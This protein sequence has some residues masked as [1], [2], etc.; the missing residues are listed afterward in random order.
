MFALIAAILIVGWL[1]GLF[2][3]HITA[4]L[5]HVILVIALV[6]LVL[7]FVRGRRSTL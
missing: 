4:A 6:M 3:F 5:F 2:A 1:L 7:H